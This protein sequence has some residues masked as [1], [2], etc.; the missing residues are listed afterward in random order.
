MEEHCAHSLV[1]AANFV[2]G[3]TLKCAGFR[4]NHL[5]V[6]RA[7][8]ELRTKLTEFSAKEEEWSRLRSSME[9]RIKE[10]ENQMASKVSK[11]TAAGEKKGFEAGHAAGNNAGTIEGREAFLKSEEFAHQVREIRLNGAQDFLK[12]PTFDSAVEIKAVDYLMQGFDRCKSQATLLNGFAS[13]F[14][15]SRL[16]PSLDANL[17]P[18]PDE[19]TPPAT[20][21]EFAVLLEEIENM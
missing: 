11:A 12:A 15:V 19:D 13:D 18:F 5:I 21:D 1:Q 8:R 3:L 14:D 10:L 6:D 16:N 17:Q 9:A 4:Q 20:D 7:N 2:R